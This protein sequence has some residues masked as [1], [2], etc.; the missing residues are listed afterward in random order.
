[1]NDLE[2]GIAY[3]TTRVI[4]Q[5]DHQYLPNPVANRLLWMLLLIILLAPT[6]WTANEIMTDGPDLENRTR[7]F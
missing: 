5:L 2:G 4:R 3:E 7:K 6:R 1:M